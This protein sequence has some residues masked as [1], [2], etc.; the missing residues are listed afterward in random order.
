MIAVFGLQV[1]AAF[2]AAGSEIA[3]D[4][5]VGG[6]DFCVCVCGVLEVASSLLWRAA[7]PSWTS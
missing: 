2:K 7:I 5:N 3:G 1:F 4:R 6:W